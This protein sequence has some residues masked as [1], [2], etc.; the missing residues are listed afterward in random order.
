VDVESL[1]DLE[2]ARAADSGSIGTA[3]AESE[4]VLGDGS[5]DRLDLDGAGL[6]D[7][8]SGD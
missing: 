2:A 1:G 5:S 7:E 4:L 6:D 8:V 3:L